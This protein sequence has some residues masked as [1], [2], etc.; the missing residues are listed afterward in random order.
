MKP[1]HVVI[2]NYRTA[3]LAV[4]CLRSLAPEVAAAAGRCQATVVD[5]G[6]ADRSAD[7]PSTTVAWHR[8]AAAAT[9]G[10]NDRRQSTANP[11]VR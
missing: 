4:D 9:S 2:V 3:G 1:V 5:G 8:P 6:S 11:A 10:A 7:P